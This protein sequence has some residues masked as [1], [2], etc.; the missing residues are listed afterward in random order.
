[1][2]ANEIASLME[3]VADELEALPLLERRLS[4]QLQ[5]ST[6]FPDRLDL[7]ENWLLCR[8]GGLASKFRKIKRQ[9]EQVA[10]GSE[11]F[12]RSDW[13]FSPCGPILDECANKI[14]RMAE[15][16]KEPTET[17]GGPEGEKPVRISVAE[18]KVKPSASTIQRAID[19]GEIISYRAKDAKKN[20]PHLVL[21]SKVI[22]WASKHGEK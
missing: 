13:L 10:T 9:I 12:R 14:R 5:L 7:I 16:L 21:Q 1:M 18:K 6:Q 17:E 19:D 8:E 15:V 11:P 22:E 3:Q 4:V 2:K 20:S